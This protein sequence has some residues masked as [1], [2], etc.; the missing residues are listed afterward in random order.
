MIAAAAL[1]FAA[2][3][4]A[5]AATVQVAILREAG[6]AQITPEGKVEILQPGAKPRPLEWKGELSLRP[7]DGGLRLLHMRLL[8]MRLKSE[9]RL[10]PVDGAR[11]RVGSNQYRGTLIL[12]LDPGQTL[13]IVEEALIEVY[14]EGVLPHEMDPN[15]PLEALKAQAVVA[16]TYTYANMG[17][18]RKDGF[19]LTADTRSQVYKGTTLV[20]ETVRAAV[21][22]TRGEVLG[23]QGKLLRVYYHAC[24]GGATTQVGA[25]WGG[26]EESPR[27][28][29]GVRDPWCAASPHMK[30]V[31]YFAWAD[32]TAAISDDRML[33]GPL[34]SL[35]IG[36]RD[37]AGYVRTFL[38]RSGGESVVVKAFELRG[39]LG[40]GEMKSVRIKSLKTL[41]KGIEFHGAG[42][43]H[44]VGLC[45]WGARLQADK[46]RSY[47][48]ILSFYFPGSVLSEV[49]E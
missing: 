4:T 29:K 25:A 32:L 20:N 34:K 12:R 24:C 27:P 42:S 48:K 21:R 47:T 1:A 28:L 41:K 23:W 38:A 22:E 10:V 43:G 16:R 2:A 19:D 40:A 8:D 5:T 33:P 15:W 11:I 3:L 46:G 14:L 17:K 49:D 26:A 31:A 13:T 39:A 37:S 18:F 30:W 36:A 6:S 9:T 7:R 44:G 35:R 45:Q